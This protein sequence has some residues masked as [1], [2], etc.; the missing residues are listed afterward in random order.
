VQGT[1]TSEI[2]LG[3]KGAENLLGKG[4]LAARLSG[5]SDV[6]FGQVPFLPAEEFADAADAL[7]EED[8][9]P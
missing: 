1:G 7:K 2:A 8:G 4:H 5:E 6:I 9:Q 3:M